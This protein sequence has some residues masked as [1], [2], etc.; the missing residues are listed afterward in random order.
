MKPTLPN[1]L[2]SSDDQ[3]SI[4][5]C[6]WELPKSEFFPFLFSFSTDLLS[7][8]NFVTR[9]FWS[10]VSIGCLR[11]TFWRVI[12]EEINREFQ[13][14]SIRYCT[15]SYKFVDFLWNAQ[16]WRFTG[17]DRQWHRCLY[18]CHLR[19]PVHN[20]CSKGTKG[21]VAYVHM[22]ICFR[23]WTLTECWFFS[24]AQV[25][26]IDDSIGCSFPRGGHFSSSSSS[27]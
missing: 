2:E 1:F 4:Y 13:G 21:K 5:I 15:I 23:L 10:N 16:A 25:H 17:C 3:V 19:C 14:T 18:T 11:G 7:L 27:P 12:K 20:P 22:C 26:D 6:I 24:S 9:T 8:L